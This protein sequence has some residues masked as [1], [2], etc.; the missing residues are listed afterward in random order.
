MVDEP[1]PI[2]STFLPLD[3]WFVVFVV[4]V[5]VSSRSVLLFSI[6]FFSSFENVSTETVKSD[7]SANTHLREWIYYVWEQQAFDRALMHLG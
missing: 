6:V 7:A 1:A 2:T 3:Q 4:L 5:I